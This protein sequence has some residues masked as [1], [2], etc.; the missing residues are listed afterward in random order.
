MHGPVGGR[1]VPGEHQAP[2]DSW[3]TSKRTTGAMLVQRASPHFRRGAR[4]R[5][6]LQP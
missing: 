5:A 2:Q 4:E 1:P 6:V 3:W